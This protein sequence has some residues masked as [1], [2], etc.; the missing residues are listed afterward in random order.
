MGDKVKAMMDN[1]SEWKAGY[2]DALRSRVAVVR[3]ERATRLNDVLDD[4]YG[5]ENCGNIDCLRSIH[6]RG[7][8]IMGCIHWVSN[9]CAVLRHERE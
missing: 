7:D 5:C 1:Y 6:E 4:R 3:N 8:E 2:D 9:G